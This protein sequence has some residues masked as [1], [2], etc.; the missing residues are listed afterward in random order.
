MAP[1]GTVSGKYDGL[2]EIGVT[3]NGQ[4]LNGDVPPVILN[5]RTLVPVRMVAE[6]LGCTV[7][8]SN[9]EVTITAPGAGSTI[10]YM[11]SGGSIGSLLSAASQ[12]DTEAP[13]SSMTGEESASKSL[14][15]TVNN[16]LSDNAN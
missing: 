4:A 13:D 10:N 1:A 11:G 5:G 12:A 14:D 16:A 6:A 15:T 3:V 8:Y 9:G 7:N 2:P